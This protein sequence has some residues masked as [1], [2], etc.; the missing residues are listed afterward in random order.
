MAVVSYQIHASFSLIGTFNVIGKTEII[1]IDKVN[2]ICL[3]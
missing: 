3:K 1:S 2:I